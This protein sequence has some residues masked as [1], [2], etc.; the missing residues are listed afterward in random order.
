LAIWVVTDWTG[1]VTNSAPME[2]D[3]L[4]WFGT[5]EWPAVSLA[6]PE[7]RTVLPLALAVAREASRG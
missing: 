1:Q 2:H 7:Y 3:D 5:G 6:H 4:R